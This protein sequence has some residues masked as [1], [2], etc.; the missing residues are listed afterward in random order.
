M[1]DKKYKNFDE[2]EF[3]CN[4]CN[5]LPEQG[6][7]DRLIKIL[8]TARE[9]VGAPIHVTSGYRCPVHNK[10]VG[11]APQSYHMRG[12]AADVYCDGIDVYG[13][14][15]AIRTAMEQECI[16]GGLQEYDNQGFVHVDTR[17]Y[18]CEWC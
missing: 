8:N 12:Q 16:E 3:A 10:N 6:I 2:S 5:Q 18:W 17:G 4:H 9:I 7:D 1:V 15:K 13:L 14:K 11:G